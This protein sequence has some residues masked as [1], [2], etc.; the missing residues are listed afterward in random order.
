[1]P[2]RTRAASDDR[3]RSTA[4]RVRR[5]SLKLAAPLAAVILLVMT[6]SVAG[7]AP[8][9]SMAPTGAPVAS[10]PPD[11]S[12]QPPS[13]S[14]QTTQ[15]LI[16]DALT[17]GRI[18]YPT[19]LLYRAYAM[20]GDPK[21]PAAY[22]GAMVEDTLLFPEI[23]RAAGSLPPDVATA[24]IPYTVRPTDPRSI[25][26]APITADAPQPLALA[27][28]PMAATSDIGV[29]QAQDAAVP[30]DQP[31]G[32]A[33][34]ESPKGFKVWARCYGAYS[35]PIRTVYGLLDQLW[36]PETAL[37]GKPLPD[38]GGPEAGGDTA[39]DVYLI[40]HY[41]CIERDGRCTDTMYQVR[42]ADGNV[43]SIDSALGVAVGTG[44]F[45]GAPGAQRASGYMLISLP[46]ARTNPDLIGTIA[47]EFF[48]V[49]GFAHNYTGMWDGS[50]ATNDW[51]VESS[52]EWAGWYFTSVRSH[53]HSF[54]DVFMSST[55]KAGPGDV[56]TSTP[57]DTPSPSTGNFTYAAW[58][59]H[60]FRQM[61]AKGPSAIAAEW[62]AVE[63]KS[64]K[65]AWDTALDAQYPFAAHLRDFAV[66]NL[67]RKLDPNDLLDPRYPKMDTELPAVGA[68]APFEQD[69]APRPQAEPVPVDIGRAGSVYGHWSFTKDVRQ[70][71]LDAS[72]LTPS[73]D[74]DVDALVKAKGRWERRK[75]GHGVTTFCRPADDVSELYVVLTNHAF[76]DDAPPVRGDVLLSALAEPCSGINGTISMSYHS[77]V[78]DPTWNTHDVIDDQISLSVQFAFR[79]GEWVDMGSSFM[80]VGR[81]RQ[82][83]DPQCGGGSDVDTRS[84]SSSGT[85]PH[86]PGEQ[87]S[88][89]SVGLDEDGSPWVQTEIAALMHGHHS[90]YEG[91]D[92]GVASDCEHHESD[93]SQVLFMPVSCGS[94]TDAVSGKLSDDGTSAD[95]SCNYTET[96]P[97]NGGTETNTWDVSGILSIAP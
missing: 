14:V 63:G 9:P 2:R 3:P 18:D 7:Q 77:D 59:W 86:P 12:G 56:L 76:L 49:L 75:L 57:L 81:E 88:G 42:D 92:G 31:Y 52:A 68:F 73:G 84:W 36:G 50:P 53:E 15:G 85:F 10:L 83:S 27:A 71:R 22:A 93:Y 67:N 21:L 78:A 90:G 25:H 16:A 82:T 51:L 62:Q 96:L 45:A 37:M 29:A 23:E 17:G 97:A 94:D 74:L 64:G 47:H 20:F 72:A 54:F 19:S 43:T 80:R 5:G 8:A 41:M 79:D 65:R 11:A 46:E 1:M 55:A 70:V 6:V 26:S 33:S 28:D 44:P 89:I 95:V 61:E 60:L 87:D 40:D 58:V 4:E 32:W 69:M 38:A 66:R 91:L 48:H 39:M 24:L 35:A 13:P 34:M 30:C